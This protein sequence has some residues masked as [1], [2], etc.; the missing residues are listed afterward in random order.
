M[1][2]QVS[3]EGMKVSLSIALSGGRIELKKEPCTPRINQF[4]H[5]ITQNLLSLVIQEASN[6]YCNYHNRMGRTKPKKKVHTKATDT[7]ALHSSS[8][9]P[10]KTPSIPALLEKAQELITQY[11]YE[12]ALRFVKRVL[13]QQPNDVEAKEMLGVCLLE[14]GELDDAKEVSGGNHLFRYSGQLM[15]SLGVPISCPTTFTT[16]TATFCTSLSCPTI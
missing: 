9:K 1:Q 10:A 11:D 6:Q 7:P 13:E 14:T 5:V 12:L 15:L 8:K 4:S 16:T 2:Y 3:A